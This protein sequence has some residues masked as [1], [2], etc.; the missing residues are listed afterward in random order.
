[1]ELSTLVDSI[2]DTI[3]QNANIKAVYG[4]PIHAEGKTIIPVARMGYGFGGGSGTKAGGD[5][6]ARGES[7]G[8][9]GGG[10][11]VVPLGVVEVTT[12]STRYIPFMSPGRLAA[13]AAAGML[14]GIW[15]GRRRGRRVRSF[16]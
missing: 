2:R 7:G 13:A 3:S 5:P 8:G 11:K 9:G 4:D 16:R 14:L 15:V 1:M 10:G 6:A 12:S